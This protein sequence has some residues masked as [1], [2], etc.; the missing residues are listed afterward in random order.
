MVYLGEK[1]KA[2]RKAKNITQRELGERIWVTKSM[3]SAYELSLRS[4]SY[5]VLVKIAAYFRV[6]TDYLLGLEKTSSIDTTGLTV[7][8]IAIIASLVDELKDLNN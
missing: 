2:L 6:S 4:P 5:E 3:I 8:Q 1:I 7:S